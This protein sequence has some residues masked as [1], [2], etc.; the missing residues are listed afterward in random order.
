MPFSW[1][2]HKIKAR[3]KMLYRCEMDCDNPDFKNKHPELSKELMNPLNTNHTETKK[4]VQ[5][6]M[7]KKQKYGEKPK[8]S[9]IIKRYNRI[10]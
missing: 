6:E 2:N 5:R 10:V 8:P 3:S 1:T 9:V 4:Y 7:D